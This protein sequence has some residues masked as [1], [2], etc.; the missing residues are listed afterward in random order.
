MFKIPSK[1][2]VVIFCQLIESDAVNSVLRIVPLITKE[3]DTDGRYKHCPN[4]FYELKLWF[5]SIYRHSK[6]KLC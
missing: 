5:I 1:I 4:S 3:G 6:P 2:R